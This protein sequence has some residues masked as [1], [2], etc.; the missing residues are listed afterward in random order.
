MFSAKREDSKTVSKD[1]SMDSVERDGELKVISN[2]E[3][4]ETLN[5]DNQTTVKSVERWQSHKFRMEISSSLFTDQI[6][7]ESIQ[8]S[9]WR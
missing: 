6:D 7:N 2:D 9:K 8:V 3:T 1:E 5:D 4:I